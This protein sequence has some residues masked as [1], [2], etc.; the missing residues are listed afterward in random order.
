MKT[1][2]LLLIKTP[3]RYK[4]PKYIGTLFGS[5]LYIHSD[6]PRELVVFSNSTKINQIDNIIELLKR[7]ILHDRPRN[8]SFNQE[9]TCNR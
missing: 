7:H 2:E 1:D 3:E 5:P 8:A 9:V 4:P 6:I